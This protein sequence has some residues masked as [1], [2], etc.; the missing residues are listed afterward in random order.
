MLVCIRVDRCVSTHL[1][2][3]IITLPAS[4][5]HTTF[6]RN[7]RLLLLLGV[8]SSKSYLARARCSVVLHF[9]RH[10]L[11][12]VNTMQHWTIPTIGFFKTDQR[13]VPARDCKCNIRNF[14]FC[15][16]SVLPPSAH[17]IKLSPVCFA[18]LSFL[19]LAFPSECSSHTIPLISYVLDTYI[20][21]WF[22]FVTIFMVLFSLPCFT[23]L[24]CLPL[25]DSSSVQ[26]ISNS[27][28]SQRAVS[29]VWELL[30]FFCGEG[31]QLKLKS[32]L[33]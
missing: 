12:I 19:L 4:T 15:W 33:L 3:L 14:K 9:S 22:P 18:L 7:H 25:P 10:G 17:F 21:H 11:A 2:L 26:C 8:D 23:L 24:C 31:V 28:I 6:L 30:F 32:S 13:T 27:N 5:S 29:S 20:F 16:S 1:Q